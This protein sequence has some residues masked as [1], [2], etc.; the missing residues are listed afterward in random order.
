MGPQKNQQLKCKKEYFEAIKYYN[1]VANNN[2][3]ILDENKNK[4]EEAKIACLTSINIFNKAITRQ[5]EI[6]KNNIVNN[7][8]DKKNSF[9]ENFNNLKEKINNL[10]NKKTNENY[11]IEQEINTINLYNSLSKLDNNNAQ[12]E[13]G[14]FQ[15]KINQEIALNHFENAAINGHDEAKLKTIKYYLGNNT[16]ERNKY[17]EKHILNSDISYKN[18][19]KIAEVYKRNNEYKAAIRFYNKINEKLKNKEKVKDNIS[20]IRN[21]FIKIGNCFVKLGDKFNNN[22]QKNIANDYYTNAISNYKRFENINKN[23]YPTF[24]SQWKI[25]NI[26]KKFD[27]NKKYKINLIKL[28][29]LVKDLQKEDIEKKDEKEK[30]YL[31]KIYFNLA[32][33]YRYGLF[34]YKY[35]EYKYKEYI[36][37]KEALKYYEKAADLGDIDSMYEVGY[38]LENNI[39]LKNEKK[40]LEYFK[41]IVNLC[42]DTRQNMAAIKITKLFLNNSEIKEQNK[43]KIFELFKNLKSLKT[44]FDIAK[45]LEQKGEILEENE[46][47]KIFKNIIETSEN[48]DIKTN[49]LFELGDIYSQRDNEKDLK[50]SLNCYSNI[51]NLDRNMTNEKLEKISDKIKF[52]TIKLN[53]LELENQT[54]RI[55]FAK[56]I[57][58]IGGREKEAIEIFEELKNCENKAIK[59][60]ALFELG[61][62]Y[63]EKNSKKDLEYARN[64]FVNAIDTN[65]TQTDIRD[66]IY[67]KISEI[68]KKIN[69]PNFIKINIQDKFLNCINDINEHFQNILPKKKNDFD[70]D[71]I[72]EGYIMDKDCIILLP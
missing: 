4:L 18:C 22:E 43:D 27:N 1:Y 64:C 57:S 58:L 68:D 17:I 31:T 10:I 37:F 13:C 66:I 70:E 56:S 65:P 69:D 29:L 30:K 2:N 32:N 35:K 12:Y 39:E 45:M 20:R 21:I 55:D 8:K 51:A 59:F 6:K 40:A 44:K 71:T 11:N 16:V 3:N 36:N 15:K 62:I 60:D 25:T 42:Q 14:I 67:D 24:E 54:K 48:C 28:S 46:A 61:N 63:C 41:K 7:T 52:V 47:I 53:T 5:V 9:I 19:K 33:F 49:S 26:Y 38:L 72:K 50:Y 23:W 34:S